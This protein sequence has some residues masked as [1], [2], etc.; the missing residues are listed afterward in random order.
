V[1]RILSPAS[2]LRGVDV[3]DAQFQTVPRGLDVLL[4]IHDMRSPFSTAE[5]SQYDI[6]H[7]RL[8]MYAFK[9]DE[10]PK[11]IADHVTFLKPAGYLFWEDTNCENWN[12]IPPTVA[13]TNFIIADERA[14]LAAGR[15][16][17]FVNKLR[18]CF[19]GAGLLSTVESTHSSF[20]LDDQGRKT[21]NALMLRLHEQSAKEQ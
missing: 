5:L 6:V 12:C 2:T 18:R 20:D 13:W 19:E 11:V 4:Q 9:A 17:L 7:A 8:L 15:Y 16:L 1:G 3:T 14:A 21:A 10:W